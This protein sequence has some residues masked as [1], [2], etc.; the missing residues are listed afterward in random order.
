MYVINYLRQT[1]RRH[2]TVYIPNVSSEHKSH[3]MLEMKHIVVIV[4]NLPIC[5]SNY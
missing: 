5:R 4:N 2:H 1:A 3:N